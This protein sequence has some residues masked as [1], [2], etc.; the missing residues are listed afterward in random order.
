LKYNTVI[1]LPLLE[2]KQET[3]TIYSF[4][5]KKDPAFQF[6]AGQFLNIILPHEN[7][8]NRG[9]RRFFSINTSPTEDFLMITTRVIDHGS[10][11]KQK[12]L[13]L[14]IGSEIEIEGVHG[15]FVLPDG[16][17]DCIFITGGIGITPVR[18]ML[19]FAT[20]KQL[21]NHLVLLY[22]NSS[23]EEVPFHN[24][25]NELKTQNPNLDIVFTVTKPEGSKVPWS[26]RVG[27]IDETLVKE[28]IRDSKNTIF[29]LCGP[30]SLVETFYKLLQGI[31]VEDTSIKRENFTGY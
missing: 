8:D 28:K 4:I 5:F 9:M 25:L 6:T 10:T 30:P 1:K 14:P 29:Y 15:R 26:G 12:L 27:R 21:P 2:I 3:P 18:S 24:F 16:G 11:F 22:S 23:P 17:Q 20:D 19:K 13:S 7:P 31:G